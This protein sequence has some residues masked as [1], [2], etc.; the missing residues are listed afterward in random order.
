MPYAAGGPIRQFGA[1]LHN[2][3]PVDGTRRAWRSKTEHKDATDFCTASFKIPSDC[4]CSGAYPART[5]VRR[6]AP[7]RARVGRQRRNAVRPE[8]VCFPDLGRVGH[9]DVRRLH[10]AGSRLGAHQKRLHDLPEEHR[11]LFH[12]RIGLF[13][14]RLQPDVQQRAD[15]DRHRGVA[16]VRAIRRRD[17][18]AG[19]GRVCAGGGDRQ[20]SLGDVRL[21]LPD[22]L[23][24]HNRFHHFRGNGRAREDV[25]FLPVHPPD[26]RVHLPDRGRL[27]LG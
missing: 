3:Q 25:E 20:Q 16:A 15:R 22:G 8:Y 12:S 6:L 23:R 10:D 4:D 2:R 21:V 11:H 17:R 19:R 24:R 7:Y 18:A 1:A 26:H 9:V 13:L 27:D 14:H 5:G